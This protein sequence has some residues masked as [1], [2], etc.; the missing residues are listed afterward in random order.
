MYWT[1]EYQYR[2]GRSTKLRKGQ[3]NIK[4][5]SFDTAHLC[6]TRKMRDNLSL[7]FDNTQ[8]NIN[9]E[10]V[11]ADGLVNVEFCPFTCGNGYGETFLQYKN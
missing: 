4:H 1:H 6:A 8:F 11:L 2:L 3:C 5:R 10:N 7:D 9:D